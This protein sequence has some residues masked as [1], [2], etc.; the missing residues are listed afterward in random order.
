MNF[1]SQLC[2]GMCGLIVEGGYLGLQD[3]E[4]WQ[5]WCSNDSVWVECFCC[6]LFEQVF[7]D[8]YQQLVFVLLNVVQC[9][10]LVVL[11]SWNNGVML[12]VMLQVIFFVVQ[13]D[14]FVFLQVCD[15]FFYYLCG[16]YDV[17]FC[18]IVQMFVVDF[19]FIYYV[20]YNVYWD[21]LVVVI[22]CLVQILVS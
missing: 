15:F 16:E 22:V 1:V 18:V 20:G 2:V 14:L 10:L 11:C 13:V 21:N 3:V 8:W 4:V 17:K 12:V 5:V 7:V 9:E 6:E 19:Y